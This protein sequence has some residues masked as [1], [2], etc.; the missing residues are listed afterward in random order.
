M[1]KTDE[2]PL[3]PLFSNWKEYIENFGN[4]APIEV[5]QKL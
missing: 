4:V 3:A 1:L 5:E 2:T